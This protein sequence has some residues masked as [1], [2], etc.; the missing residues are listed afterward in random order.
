MAKYNLYAPFAGVKD[1]LTL[2]TLLQDKKKLKE[3]MG[4]IVALEDERQG[5]NEAI[6]VYGKAKK[7]DGLLS[8]AETKDR[9]AD[10]ALSA[11]KESAGQ[12]QKD[13]KTWANDL[14]SKIV[15]REEVVTA[16]EKKLAENEA[17]HK[18]DV[19]RWEDKMK[20]RE[21]EVFK[22]QRELGGQI[23]EAKE[24]KERHTVALASMKAGVAAA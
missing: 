23:A 5:L 10:A 17:H 1:G 21:T 16:G 20:K 8:A 24:I 6:E 2:L 18:A 15:E 7:M 3:I 11:A 4:V 19:D 13:A 12:I 22:Q 14:R 9:E